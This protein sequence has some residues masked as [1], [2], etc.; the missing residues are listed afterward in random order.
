MT[1]GCEEDCYRAL[2][3]YF[4]Y[5]NYDILMGNSVAHRP[6]EVYSYRRKPSSHSVEDESVTTSK[7]IVYRLKDAENDQQ[8]MFIRAGLGSGSARI[9]ENSK[10]RIRFNEKVMVEESVDTEDIPRSELFYTK[11]D[12]HRQ[13][14]EANLELYQATDLEKEYTL[15]DLK[16]LLYQ[17]FDFQGQPICH[18]LIVTADRAIS[19]WIYEHVLTIRYGGEFPLQTLVQQAQNEDELNDR[20]RSSVSVFD[21]IFIDEAIPVD[22]GNILGTTPHSPICPMHHMPLHIPN[23]S[24]HTLYNPDTTHRT[25]HLMCRLDGEYAG[26]LHRRRDHLYWYM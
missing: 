2:K 23:M 17:P 21:F 10:T 22:L 15:R 8:T 4:K 26:A 20:L 12:Y 13:K 16:H 18:V 19:N 5:F 11:V 24:T 7:R 9:T 6:D 14:A 25:T 1:W 3:V